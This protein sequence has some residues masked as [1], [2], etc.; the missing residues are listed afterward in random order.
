MSDKEIENAHSKMINLSK[1]VGFVNGAKWMRDKLQNQQIEV[2][3][4]LTIAKE[5]W[6][7]LAIATGEEGLLPEDVA[8]QAIINTLKK[9]EK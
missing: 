8:Y 9:L 7:T 3:N 4:T 5:A 6:E 1:S 2:V